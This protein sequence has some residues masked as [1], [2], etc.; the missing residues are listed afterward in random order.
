MILV[1]SH[2]TSNLGTTDYFLEYLRNKKKPYY[3]LR[4]PMPCSGI[5]ESELLYFDGTSVK[6]QSKHKSLTSPPLDYIR[7]VWLNLVTSF[8][9]RKQIQ[10]VFG[11]GAFNI[12][13]SIF[14]SA[15]A[16]YST[17][18]YGVDYS[19]KRFENWILNYI[20]KCLETF[21]CKNATRTISS[22]ERQEH[23]RIRL[24]HLRKDRSLVVPNGIST[25]SLREPNKSQIGNIVLLYVG[26]ITRNHGIIEFI[27]MVYCKNRISLPLHI[28]GAGSSQHELVSAIQ[29]CDASNLVTYHGKAQPED[30]RS[31]V[32]NSKVSF[33]G[34]APYKMDKSSHVYFG[35][36]LKIK[37][38]LS[39]GMPYICTEQIGVPGNL[40]KF[41]LRYKDYDALRI[42]LSSDVHTLARTF[43]RSAL[44][45]ILNEYLW[46][47]L[48]SKIDIL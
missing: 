47:N 3:Y 37:E 9:L 6:I 36:S 4:H 15:V 41:G 35:D 5:G 16:N 31:F 48:F 12:A 30:I 38:Y 7:C 22:S 13:P 46:S 18:F 24:H 28:F 42:I 33:V 40:S 17:I 26:A 1:I 29:K 44:P 34:I 27:E 11:F 10:K 8:K 39:M 19:P 25:V 45:P 2:F 43:D 23:A 32:Q 14:L 20:Y 21:A